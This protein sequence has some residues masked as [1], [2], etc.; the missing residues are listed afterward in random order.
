ME[1]PALPPPNLPP[2]RETSGP[3]DPAEQSAVHAASEVTGDGG[4]QVELIFTSLDQ[5]VEQYI[6]QVVHRR[7]NRSVSVWCPEWWRH[8]E[9]VARFSV[10]WRAFEYLRL[11]PAL[12]MSMWWLQ[13]ADPHLFALMHPQYGPFTAC[14]PREGHAEVPPGPLPTVP[15]PLALRR[16][17]AFAMQESDLAAMAARQTA[18]ESSA[19]SIPD[20]PNPDADDDSGGKR[21][22]KDKDPGR[23]QGI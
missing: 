15:A 17:P 6:T 22:T 11:D 7:L 23:E 3:R 12:G 21:K 19:R 14:D 4:P 18:A 16:H 5:F 1:P 2:L 10:L 9:A 13:H 20:P 8:P